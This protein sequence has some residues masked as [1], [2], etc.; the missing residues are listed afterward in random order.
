VDRRTRQRHARQ[1]MVGFLC[2]LLAGALALLV[3]TVIHG[4]WNLVVT[5]AL[6]CLG[7]VI[8]IVAQLRRRI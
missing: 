3:L 4:H 2:L 8:Q 7:F 1:E 5:A 6:L